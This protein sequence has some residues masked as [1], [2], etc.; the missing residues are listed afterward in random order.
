LAYTKA[1][2]C[3]AYCSVVLP[4]LPR[5]PQQCLGFVTITP[6]FS[7]DRL[8]IV[9]NVRNP[10]AN[11]NKRN[12]FKNLSIDI[13]WGDASPPHS[14]KPG[15]LGPNWNHGLTAAHLVDAPSRALSAGLS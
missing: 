15:S 9:M 3:Q 8:V 7:V 10:R 11:N 5:R 2:L 12:L 13:L 6:S 14:R 4:K 1:K